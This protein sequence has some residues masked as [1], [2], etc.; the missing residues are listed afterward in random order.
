MQFWSISIV[1]NPSLCLIRRLHFD[2]VFFKLQATVILN[3]IIT[4]TELAS[5][6][7]NGYTFI[8]IIGMS[9][10]V[11][12]AWSSTFRTIASNIIITISPIIIIAL[13][14]AIQFMINHLTIGIIITLF[15]LGL[16]SSIVK[17]HTIIFA[18]VLLWSQ[19]NCFCGY[20]LYSLILFIHFSCSIRIWI[21][22]IMN[23]PLSWDKLILISISWLF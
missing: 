15:L 8:L 14:G 22:T 19:V 13:R 10:I 2:R 5:W 9:K 1:M 18:S 23:V 3:C 4:F 16:F 21:R 7:I 6:W 12:S 17:H 20:H 11:W